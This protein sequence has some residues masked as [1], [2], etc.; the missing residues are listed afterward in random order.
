MA[1]KWPSR[2]PLVDILY[3]P[4]TKEIVLD[5]NMSPFDSKAVV[6]VTEI[7]G[8]LRLFK[9]PK[10]LKSYDFGRYRFVCKEMGPLVR[11]TAYLI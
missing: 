3:N 5:F 7:L 8:N 6:E 1:I 4:K 2:R 9:E 10:T 11:V